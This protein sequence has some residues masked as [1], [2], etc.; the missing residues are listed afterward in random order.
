MVHAVY[1]MKQ[2][3]RL[4]AAI[5][6]NG[7]LMDLIILEMVYAQMDGIQNIGMI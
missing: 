7:T 3:T 5:S 1:H 2:S 4:N 6:E